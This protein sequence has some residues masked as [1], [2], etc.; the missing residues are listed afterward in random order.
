[1][2]FR[3]I[4]G[5]M[6]P[7]YAM[8]GHFS[9]GSDVF[10]FGVLVLEIICGKRNSCFH[11]AVH[12]KDFLSHAWKMWKDGTPL[13]LMD[14][15]LVDSHVRN[16]VMRCIQMGLLCVQENVDSRPSVAAIVLMLSSYNVSFPLPK[17]PPFYFR[18]RIES[19]AP[20]GLELDKSRSKSAA[21]V[22]VDKASITQSSK[23]FSTVHSDRD[24]SSLG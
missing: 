10:S 22:S 3:A 2:S 13:E 23:V 16:E 21:M 11:P 8:H 14:P 17:Q 7:E 24:L 15:T 1:M 20:E 4:S 12:G 18:S 19:E 9:V 6:S 5:Y